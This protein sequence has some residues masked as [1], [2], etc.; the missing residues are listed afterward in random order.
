MKASKHPQE[1]PKLFLCLQ[2]VPT[3]ISQLIHLLSLTCPP[4]LSALRAELDPNSQASLSR[5]LRTTLPH[6]IQTMP[7]ED[8]TEAKGTCS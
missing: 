5:E 3:L 8:K 1:L 2:P 7:L 6:L 4:S